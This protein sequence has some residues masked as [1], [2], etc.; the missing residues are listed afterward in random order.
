MPHGPKLR[1]HGLRSSAS[2]VLMATGLV[3]GK[4]Q[5]STPTESTLL[6]RSPKICH[7]WLHW[8]PLHLCQI[9]CTSVYGDFWANGWNIT[10]I[11]IYLCPFLGTH[12]HFTGVNGF[13][14]MMAQTMRTEA[15]M[16]LFLGFV[17]TAPHLRVKSPKTPILAAWTGT[18]KPN[19][20]NGKT[21]IL[22][23]LLHQ[24]R[25]NLAQ[26]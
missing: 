5:F 26:W 22:S 7:R 18:F 24:F 1:S 20:W 9:W 6:N 4:G 17:D 19:S 11:I 25:S 10:Q 8:Q 16:C 15:R 23:K 2:P 14:H 12:L 21:C 3:N 13:S